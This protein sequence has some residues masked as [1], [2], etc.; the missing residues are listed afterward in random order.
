MA[1]A[2]AHSVGL[3]VRRQHPNSL[4]ALSRSCG[5]ASGDRSLIAT[6]PPTQAALLSGDGNESQKMAQVGAEVGDAQIY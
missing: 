2:H 1:I 6:S 4:V 5:S 3:A